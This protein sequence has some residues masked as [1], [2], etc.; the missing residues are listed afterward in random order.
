MTGGERTCL[1]DIA[2]KIGNIDA[3]LTGVERQRAEDREIWAQIGADVKSL[4]SDRDKAKGATTAVGALWP[5]V[6]YLAQMS[7]AGIAAI[8]GWQRWGAS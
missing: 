4:L 2:E 5:V 7:I 3:R 6:K 1:A 8:L